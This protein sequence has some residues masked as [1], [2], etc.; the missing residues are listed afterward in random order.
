MADKPIVQYTPTTIPIIV[1]ERASVKT[2]DHPREELNRAPWVSTSQV[3]EY[4]EG[5]GEF[6]T[7]NTV[8][9]LKK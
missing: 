2:Y 6:Q 9:V 5:S 7:L 4:D 8:Y 1:G 3:L